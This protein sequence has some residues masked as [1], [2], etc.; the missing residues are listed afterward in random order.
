MVRYEQAAFQ[1]IRTLGRTESPKGS[2]QR[3]LEAKLMTLKFRLALACILRSSS[4][5]AR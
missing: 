1:G 5:R 4:R 2:P 3:V